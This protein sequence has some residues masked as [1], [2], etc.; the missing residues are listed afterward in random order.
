MCLP[1]A[2]HAVSCLQPL[3]IQNIAGRG[4]L[5]TKHLYQYLH[6]DNHLTSWMDLAEPLSQV[7]AKARVYT[8]IG[9][10]HFEHVREMHQVTSDAIYVYMCPILL[11]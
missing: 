9:C 6:V 10:P 7:A 1:I 3:V 2:Q 5:L 4:Y 11:V 8:Y